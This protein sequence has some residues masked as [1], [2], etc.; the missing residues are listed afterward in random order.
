[1][2]DILK[3]LI[4]SLLVFES[5]IPRD[6]FEQQ[7]FINLLS[8]TKIVGVYTTGKCTQVTYRT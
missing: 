4:K 3:S 8:N 2:D 1:M 6:R 5:Q 7:S